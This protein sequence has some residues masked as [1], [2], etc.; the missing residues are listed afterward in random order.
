MLLVT[1]RE[2]TVPHRSEPDEGTRVDQ[3]ELASRF[4]AGEHEAAE[5]VIALYLGPITRRV[6]RLLAWPD[7]VADVVQ[8]VFAAA[9]A[10][11]RRFR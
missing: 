6:H 4:V 7:D 9:L 5:E 8:E 2:R 10:G 1:T 3:E 11:R